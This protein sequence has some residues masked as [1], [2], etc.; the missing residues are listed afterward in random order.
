MKDSPVKLTVYIPIEVDTD[1]RVEAAKQRTSVS[2][3]ATE[4]FKLY[5]STRATDRDSKP[6]PVEEDQDG[7]MSFAPAVA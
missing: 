5:L 4:A 7:P 3:V 2:A 1:M 6:A